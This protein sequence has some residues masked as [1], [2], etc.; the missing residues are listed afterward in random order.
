MCSIIFQIFSC[1][2]NSPCILYACLSYTYMK[3]S[4][5]GLQR[6]GLTYRCTLILQ[7]DTLILL[8]MYATAVPQSSGHLHWYR[9]ETNSSL[10]EPTNDL[11]QIAFPF[12]V[13]ID[14]PIPP[15]G[16]QF[17]L[18][19]EREIWMVLCLGLVIWMYTTTGV[20]LVVDFSDMHA[21]RFLGDICISDAT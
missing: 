15:V 8:L 17:N 20:S 13:M 7:I 18:I 2:W 1:K 6:H 10:C 16:L 9:H 4:I 3:C 11:H 5:A 19:P 12:L 21:V 14:M